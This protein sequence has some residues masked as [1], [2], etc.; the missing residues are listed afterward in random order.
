YVENGSAN[1][2]NI[3]R[4]MTWIADGEVIV[5]GNAGGTRAAYMAAGSGGSIFH[6]ITFDGENVKTDT[7]N[8]NQSFT[9]AYFYN[10]IFLNGINYVANFY[11]LSS[12]TDLLFDSCTFVN[13]TRLTCTTLA[14]ASSAVNNVVV[15]NCTFNS[16]AE[17]NY[18]LQI[19]TESLSV[20]SNKTAATVSGNRFYGAL[21]FDL[22]RI[23][24]STHGLLIGTTHNAVIK[25]NYFNG[26]PY[27]VVVKHEGQLFTGA[28][29]INN[30]F[31]NCCSYAAM[32][33]KGARNV[34][35]INNTVWVDSNFPTEGDGLRIGQN[36]GLGA[37]AGCLSRNNLF[38]VIGNGKAIN[39]IDSGSQ[40]GFGSNN[41]LL[42]THSGASSVAKIT[43]VVKTFSEWQALG[44]DLQGINA[45]PKFLDPANGDFRLSRSS[46]CINAG[47]D[48][49]LT[50]DFKGWPVPLH[51]GFD[52]GAHEYWERG[53]VLSP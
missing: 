26:C 2:W 28:G 31:V 38:V 44:Y 51:G 34:N 4:R 11:A 40:V 49:G 10:C 50:S 15:R 3:N 9:G 41:N 30:I 17:G 36:S 43:G 22:S 35:F 1:C 24:S 5:R 47:A 53:P 42:Y 39:I 19:G 29:V 48:V 8:C 16:R 12:L 25:G 14:I 23:S 46:P 13:T 45:D 32:Y 27:G 37:A 21:F 7:I 33:S 52:I 18:L 20:Y 6:G